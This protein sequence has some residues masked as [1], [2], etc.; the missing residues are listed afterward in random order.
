MSAPNYLLE[1]WD[2]QSA[3]FLSNLQIIRRKPAKKAV[4]DIRVAIKKMKSC[5]LLA[6]KLDA[7]GGEL[8]FPS[9]QQF[10]RVTGKYR[11]TDMSRALLRKTGREE[12]ISIPPLQKNL[13]MMLSVTRRFVTDHA[14]LPYES[15]LKDL[16]EKI[17]NCLSAVPAEEL[18]S[19][20]ENLAAELLGEIKSLFGKFHHN[21]HPLRIRL[22]QLYYWLSQCPV[23]PFFDAKQM[24][25]M[26][27]ALTA[28]GNWHD[29]FVL[30]EKIRRF[31][32][33]YL[34][35]NTADQL[36]AKKLEEITKLLQEQWLV[37]AEDKL[38]SLFSPQ[39]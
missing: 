17:Y 18:V 27:K 15:E 37:G 38:N 20:T 21:A 12:N 8:A 30:H 7:S 22:K 36:H 31:R 26:D 28:L 13:G 24:K 5:L 23:N 29:Y 32:K 33:E 3:V 14:G 35:P 9:I 19:R 10:F 2:E 1:Y 39:K 4:H 16:S 11:D 6:N 25:E 34:V